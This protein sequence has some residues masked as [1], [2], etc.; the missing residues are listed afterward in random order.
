MCDCGKTVDYTDH[1]IRDVLID[2]IY[3]SDIRRETLGLPDIL[4]KLVNDVIA[5]VENKK[6]ACNALLSPTLS[7]MSSFQRLKK[8]STDGFCPSPIPSRQGKASL[9]PGLQKVL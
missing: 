6:M 4:H 7:A 3:D 9:M 2:D 1:I 8:A 5:R